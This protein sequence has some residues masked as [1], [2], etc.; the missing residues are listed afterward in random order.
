MASHLVRLKQTAPWDS[1][2]PSLLKSIPSPTEEDFEVVTQTQ[3]LTFLGAR[4]Q[5]DFARLIIKMTPGSKVLE[6]KSLK[7]YL[8]Q[9]RNVLLSYERCANII[10]EHLQ[11][12]CSP[13]TLILTIKCRPRGGLRT[14]ITVDSR[15]REAKWENPSADPQPK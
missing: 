12:A 4:G 15:R 11:V 9:F 8:H 5:P 1:I 3:E 7:K 2:D 6:L 10:F 14:T 13:K